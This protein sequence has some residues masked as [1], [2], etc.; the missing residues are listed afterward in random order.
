MPS[1]TPEESHRWPKIIMKTE[2]LLCALIC[3]LAAPS[4]TW[5]KRAGPPILE[6]VIYENIEYTAPNDNGRR[7]YIEAW[8]LNTGKKLWEQTIFTTTIIPF[9]EEDV[10]WV[11]IKRFKVDNGNILITDEKERQYLL[12]PT[13][14]KVKRLK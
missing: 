3:L 5:S 1:L 2:I 11:L 6:P 9:L 12:N 10:Q 14:R 7:A 4:L 13:T 8:D